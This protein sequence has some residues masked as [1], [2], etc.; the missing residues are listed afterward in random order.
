VEAA[1]LLFEKQPLPWIK[2]AE[3]AKIHAV[4]ALIESTV[5]SAVARKQRVLVMLTGV[6]GSGKTL[7]GL[8]L[9]HSRNLA[10]PAV[11]LS[12]NGPLIQ[13]LQY[14]LGRRQEFVQ[15]IKPF[16]RHHLIRKSERTRER[17]VVFDEA[18]RAWDRNR[19]IERHQGDLAA[20]EPELLLR[21]AEQGGEG[22]GLV[23]LMGEGQ[24]IH[25]GEE[26]GIQPWIDA[27]RTLGNWEVV[28]P[29]H[30]AE[31][32]RSAGIS[33]REHTLLNLTTT[34]RSHRASRTSLWVELVLQGK[35]IEAKKVAL[36]L[37]QNQFTLH[38]T[39]DLERLQTHIR[40]RYEGDT[41]KRYGVLV[42]SKFRSIAEYGIRAAR[43]PYYYYGEWYSSPPGNP[44]SSC[45]MDL[46]VSE[47]GCQGLEL[48]YPLLCWGPDLTWDG[49]Q[50]KAKVGKPRKVRDPQRL[51]LNAYRVLL[52]RGRDGVGIFVPSGAKMDQTYKALRDAG[53]VEI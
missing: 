20:S 7:V 23:A 50:W 37:R 34:L 3:S 51:R 12:G 39:R 5:R 19:V 40:E 36:D 2:Q 47:F 46:A 48:D 33:Y 9:V 13:V 16:L 8:Q 35:L 29:T 42:S 24:E 38:M 18:Q 21:V 45:Q 30:L 22:F 44:R 28:G 10:S 14:S 53:V 27:V 49:T 15:D 32:F 17:I 41:N 4:V 26:S 1:R 31:P 6:P 43:H 52:S 25:A 11:F